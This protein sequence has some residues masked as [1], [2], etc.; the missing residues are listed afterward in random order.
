MT[1]GIKK[2]GKAGPWIASL[3]LAMTKRNQK[4]RLRRRAFRRSRVFRVTIT[5]ASNND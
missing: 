2:P 1:K 4:A 3:A 5:V